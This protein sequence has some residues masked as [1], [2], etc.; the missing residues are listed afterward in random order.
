MTLILIGKMCISCVVDWA[1]LAQEWIKMKE[2]HI[3]SAPTPP[4]I[5]ENPRG[6]SYGEGEAPMDMECKDDE[7]PPA[8]PAPNIS[9]ASV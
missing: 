1:A 8:P 4:S 3:P 6:S 5:S 9:G 2:T 7:I